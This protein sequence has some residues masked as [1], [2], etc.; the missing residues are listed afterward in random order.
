[1]IFIIL[2]VKSLKRFI[3]PSEWGIG[4]NS[5]MIDGETLSIIRWKASFLDVVQEER[6][7]VA[8]EARFLSL[9]HGAASDVADGRLAAP[10]TKTPSSPRKPPPML[11]I[12]LTKNL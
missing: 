6:I 8:M 4:T 2:P 3:A 5:V 9:N 7:C 1:M 10:P 12:A 11:H